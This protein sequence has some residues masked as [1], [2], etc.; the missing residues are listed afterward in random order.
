MYSVDTDYSWIEEYKKIEKDYNKYYKSSPREISGYCIFVNINNEVECLLANKML[1]DKNSVLSKNSIINFINKNKNRKKY[2]FHKLLKYNITIDP[3]NIDRIIKK[4]IDSEE[5]MC[6]LHN[7]QDITFQDT[8][9]MFHR[10]NTLFFIYREKPPINIST[11]NK[12]KRNRKRMI[13]KTIKIPSKNK[14]T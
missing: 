9:E 3:I 1:L 7:I 2:T 11:S 14:H 5:Y 10:I 12:T 4:T 6:E 13:R 8:I